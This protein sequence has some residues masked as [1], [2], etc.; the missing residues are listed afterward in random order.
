MAFPNIV[1]MNTD[2][3]KPPPITTSEGA[4]YRQSYVENHFESK[5]HKACKFALNLTGELKS[6]IEIHLRKANKKL[7]SHVTKLLYDV[8]VD[9]KK[10]GNSAWS[11]PSRVVGAE[12][13]RLFEY[14]NKNSPTV[15]FL[16]LQ[17]VNPVAHLEL[18]STI[19]RSEKE[20]LER[21]LKTALY[22]KIFFLVDGKRR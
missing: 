15:P 3:R 18:L 2:N 1:K 17:Y 8:F 21:K 22:S 5:C 13:G 16:N 12:A 19:V 6:G 20:C 10:L 14:E 7:A 4:R 9:A 11:W